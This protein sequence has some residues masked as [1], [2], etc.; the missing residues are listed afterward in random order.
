MSSLGGPQS[1]DAMSGRLI[2]DVK[3]L[4]LLQQQYR[5]LQGSSLS[6]EEGVGA[7]HDDAMQQR[8]VPVLII[9]GTF[10]GAV[11]MARWA[12]EPDFAAHDWRTH[13]SGVCSQH[14]SLNVV[15]PSV[16]ALDWG[17][18]PPGPCSTC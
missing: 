12:T 13:S 15:V 3:L 16:L 5:F 10:I 7:E 1:G 11:G 6:T 14:P 9:A 8:P 2:S 18:W 4:R 17:C